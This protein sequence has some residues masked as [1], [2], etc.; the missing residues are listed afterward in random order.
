MLT[1][2]GLLL[3]PDAQDLPSGTVLFH[4]HSPGWSQGSRFPS[5]H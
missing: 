5:S 4:V 2:T 1:K 3:G